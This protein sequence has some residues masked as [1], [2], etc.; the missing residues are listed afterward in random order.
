ME[1][2]KKDGEDNRIAKSRYNYTA[3][4]LW[5]DVSIDFFHNEIYISSNLQYTD[6]KVTCKEVLRTRSEI[7]L[8]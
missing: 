6:K 2:R 5:I 7:D 3:Y 4:K 1:A 8:C